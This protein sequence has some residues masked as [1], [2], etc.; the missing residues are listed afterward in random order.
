MKNK[1]EH[2]WYWACRQLINGLRVRR[3]YWRNNDFH[4]VMSMNVNFA[5]HGQRLC[6]VDSPSG[7]P[8]PYT[9]YLNDLV[10]VDW[11]IYGN[12]KS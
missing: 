3:S 1:K 5:L 12:D 7:V 6:G 2:T 4:L 8:M 9:V 11:E 10:A